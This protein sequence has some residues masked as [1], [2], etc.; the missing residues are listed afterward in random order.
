[1]QARG[2]T[3]HNEAYRSFLRNLAEA[4]KLAK[5][6]QLQLAERLGKPQ[7]HVS[8]VESGERRL[9]VLEFVLWARELEVNPVEV[10]T[11]LLSL[12]KR[13][14]VRLNKIPESDQK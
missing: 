11:P 4:R 2:K 6:T 10:L 13:R 5:V 3:I 1:M 12:E 9:D 8:K 14:R 7:S